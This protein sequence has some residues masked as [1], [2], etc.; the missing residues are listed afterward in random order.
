MAP[1]YVP[2]A[3]Q[4]ADYMAGLKAHSEQGAR[5]HAVHPEA[6]QRAGYADH[7]LARCGI[8]WCTVPDPG[9]PFQGQHDQCRRCVQLLIEDGDKNSGTA[10]VQR[11]TELLR[12]ART[13]LIDSN[14][15]VVVLELP[16]LQDREDLVACLLYL[17]EH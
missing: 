17:R 14:E 7:F 16:T 4:P 15:R 9:R 8:R 2:A 6:L 13:H 10:L 5:V 11:T 12:R 1:V 3:W